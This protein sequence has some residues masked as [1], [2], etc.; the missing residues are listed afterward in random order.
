VNT[1]KIIKFF[2]ALSFLFV[3][4]LV[5]ATSIWR[6]SA[7][8]ANLN[9][10]VSPIALSNQ[11]TPIPSIVPE[12]KAEYILV[13]PGIL[14]DN[15]FYPI[16]MIR[17]RLVLM[18]T[19][20]PVKKAEIMLLYADKRI[21]GAQALIEGGKADLGVTTATKAEKYL[22]QSLLEVDKAQSSGKEVK[23]IKEKLNNASFKHEEILSSLLPKVTEGNKAT[24]EEA[25][26]Q[27]QRVY[28]NTLSE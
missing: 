15:I 27:S 11:V 3:G 12:P 22:E 1:T 19:T 25:I 24:L 16:K 7:K 4:S 20:D 6:V 13:Y 9:F 21:G 14:P 8:T 2:L 26:K 5:L 10:K 17:D 18:L 23:G 28:L